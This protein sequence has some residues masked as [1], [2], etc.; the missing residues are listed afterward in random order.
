MGYF[1]YGAIHHWYNDK[2]QPQFI[3]KESFIDNIA[4]VFRIFMIYCACTWTKNSKMVFSLI[5]LIAGVNCFI[6]V[7]MQVS[8]CKEGHNYYT[9]HLGE[10]L[11]SSAFTILWLLTWESLRDYKYK[12][13]LFGLC[14]GLAR[15][16]ALFGVSVAS[17]GH[18]FSITS[19]STSGVLFC[20]LGIWLICQK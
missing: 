6:I 19:C 14:C 16:G 13:G 10:Y 2:F 20:L 5:L 8:E 3:A 18:F 11:I 12:H 9:Y 7:I 15:F 17:K 1:L 4:K